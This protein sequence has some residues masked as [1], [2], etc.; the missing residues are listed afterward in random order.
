MKIVLLIFLSFGNLVLSQNHRFIYEVESKKDS[1][2]N[3]ITKEFYHLDIFSDD[4]KYYGRAY[5]EADSLI[6][7][8]IGFSAN[9]S[10]IL[11]DIIVRKTDNEYDQYEWLQYD[12]LKTSQKVSQKWILT[13]EKKTIQDHLVQK[14]ETNWGG[15]KWTAWFSPE[16]PFQYGPYKFHGLPGLI[17]EISDSQNNYVFKLVK[18]GKLSETQK[19]SFDHIFKIGVPV[20]REKYIKAK[21]TYFN[22]P[23]SFV[24]NGDIELMD[25]N[26]AL[27]QDGTKLTK[28][29]FREVRQRQQKNIRKYNNPLELDKIVNYPK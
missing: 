7:N 23:L 25:G 19:I 24:K 28:D 14:A 1:T 20:N 13:D 22:D 3:T 12:V 2:E 5:Y 17:M 18:S 27:L 4:I 15:R 16:I 6:K 10:P 9:S 8:N 11:T 29:N 26:W 21:L